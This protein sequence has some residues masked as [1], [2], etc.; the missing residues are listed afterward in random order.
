MASVQPE[1]ALMLENN[2]LVPGA[3]VPHPTVM[4]SQ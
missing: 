1:R 4:K 2:F 3:F